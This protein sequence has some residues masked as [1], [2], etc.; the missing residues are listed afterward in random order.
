MDTKHNMDSISIVE[1]WGDNKI[2]LSKKRRDLILKAHCTEDSQY[3]DKDQ[4]KNK[5]EWTHVTHM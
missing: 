3:P 5:T 4:Q 2:I 1:Q